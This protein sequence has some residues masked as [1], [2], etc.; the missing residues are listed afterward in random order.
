MND[1]ADIKQAADFAR[2]ISRSVQH[3]FQEMGK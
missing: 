2:L 3:D 1:D